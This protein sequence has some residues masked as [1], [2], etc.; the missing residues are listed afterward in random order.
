MARPQAPQMQIR[1]SAAIAL[2]CRAQILGE[3]PV[4]KAI[5]K[6]GARIANKPIGPTGNHAGPDD[7]GKGVH[8][9]PPEG[10]SEEQANNHED[11]DRRTKVSPESAR[12]EVGSFVN[13]K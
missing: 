9:K 5:E 3:S 12:Q 13:T 6:D 4:R 8:P 7:T 11:R 10:T 2:N 1:K